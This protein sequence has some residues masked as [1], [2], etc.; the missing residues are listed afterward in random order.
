MDYGDRYTIKVCVDYTDEIDEEEEDNNCRTEEIRVGYEDNNRGNDDRR[1]GIDG[2]PFQ[3]LYRVS[4]AA[5]A[6]CELFDEGIV[7]GRDR[8]SFEPQENVT[9]AE[10]LKMILLGGDYSVYSISGS[11]DYSDVDSGD[12]YYPYVTY[13]TKRGFVSGYDDG[14]FRPNDPINRAEAVVILMRTAYETLWSFTQ[15]DIPFWDV[16]REDWYAYAVVL[17]HEENIVEG[18]WDRSFRPE[19]N[20]NRAEAAIMTLRAMNELF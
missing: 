11:D 17:A 14:T 13:A 8:G 12:W 10:F 20:L 6:I 2:C 9:R 15:L 18:Y 3:D 4:W 16:D 7:N 19:E 5:E 1:G